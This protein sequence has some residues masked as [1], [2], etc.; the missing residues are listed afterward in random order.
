M[1]IA[2]FL[3]V[4]WALANVSLAVQ[5]GKWNSAYNRTMQQAP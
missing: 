4:V 2:S 5:N 3:P 1:E